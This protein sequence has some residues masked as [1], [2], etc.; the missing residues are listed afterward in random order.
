[1]E[2]QE[3][4]QSDSPS[5]RIAEVADWVRR[6]YAADYHAASSLTKREWVMEYAGA[7]GLDF[8]RQYMGDIGAKLIQVRAILGTLAE[9]DRLAMMDLIVIVESALNMTGS[10][11]PATARTLRTLPPLEWTDL[12]S[13]KPLRPEFL[14]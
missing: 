11:D 10:L 6:I 9:A 2:Q 1:M 14:H 8:N 13:T 7:H 5:I 3:I 4:E 12:G